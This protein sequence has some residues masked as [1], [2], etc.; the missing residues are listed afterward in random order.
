MHDHLGFSSYS[1]ISLQSINSLQH[2]KKNGGKNVSLDPQKTLNFKCPDLQQKWN[3][4]CMWIFFY[5]SFVSIV[6][7]A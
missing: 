1:P 2:W 4:F 5:Y 6:L 7:E 3:R